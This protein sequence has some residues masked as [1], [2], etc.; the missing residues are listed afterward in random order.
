MITQNELK[1][2]FVYSPETG[3][4]SYT[5][6]TKKKF[7]KIGTTTKLGYIRIHIGNKL[8]LAHRL[9]WLY[10]TGNY[11]IMDIDHINRI[12]ND[13]RW[14][15]LREATD[16]Q[17]ST[18]TGVRKNSKS[19]FKCVYWCNRDKRWIATGTL[20]GKKHSLGRYDNP[21]SA[22]DAYEKFSKENHGD[23]F[24]LNTARET[25]ANAS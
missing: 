24:C 2:R 12:P 14:C 18:N 19:G 9:A 13:N 10:M 4:F 21:Y 23:F 6:H 1:D 8:Y 17:N 22:R 16:M 5:E 3:I 25:Y 15:N 11:P 7:K 20:N